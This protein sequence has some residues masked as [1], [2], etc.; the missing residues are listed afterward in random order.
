MPITRFARCAAV[1]ELATLALALT[2]SGAVNA[3]S[4]AGTRESRGAA[5][6][7]TYCS[8]CHGANGNGRG[9]MSPLLDPKPTRHSDGAY[10]KAL[11]DDFMYRLIRDGGPAF[12]KSP[13]MAR[14]SRTLSDEQ[15]WNLVAYIRSLAE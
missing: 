2:I 10:M 13:M 11:S 9:P 5:D 12:G 6:Y 4:V 7:A 1:A 14:W 8:P 3:A 15:I